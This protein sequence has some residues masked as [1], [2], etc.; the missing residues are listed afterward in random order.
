MLIPNH[1]IHNVLK[2]YSKQLS[3]ARVIERQRTLE[4]G[5]KTDKISISAEG[6]RQAIIEKVASDIVDRITRSGPKDEMEKEIL[7]KLEDELGQ[8]IDF[9]FKATVTPPYQK[10]EFVFNVIEG[11]HKKTINKPHVEDDGFLLKRLEQLAKEAVD[12]NMEL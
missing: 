3:Q 1:Q 6:K 11:N 2:V 9:E 8:P 5:I 10:N 12:N 7:T 4:K